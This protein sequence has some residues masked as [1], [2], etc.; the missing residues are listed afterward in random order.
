MNK[1]VNLQIPVEL[2]KKLQQES[3]SKLLSISAVI[4][5]ILLEYFNKER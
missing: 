5:L 1:H 3:T 2:Y 4:R